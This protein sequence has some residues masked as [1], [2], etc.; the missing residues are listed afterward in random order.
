MHKPII[1]DT[2]CLLS[3]CQVRW[4]AVPGASA[5]EYLKTSETRLYFVA[6]RIFEITLEMYKDPRKVVQDGAEAGATLPTFDPTLCT[7]CHRN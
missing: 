1:L 6:D 2:K 3:H 4:I 5:Q 7:E